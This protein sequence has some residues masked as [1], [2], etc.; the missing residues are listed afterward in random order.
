MIFRISG[1][2]SALAGAPVTEETGAP[3]KEERMK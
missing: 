1:L 3:V 2:N